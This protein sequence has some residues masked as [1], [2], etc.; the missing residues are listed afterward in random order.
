MPIAAVTDSKWL[1]KNWFF[2]HGQVFYWLESKQSRLVMSWSI[3][4]R[5]SLSIAL[6]IFRSS[7]DLHEC[8]GKQR[9]LQHATRTA[10]TAGCDDV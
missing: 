4:Q 8:T 6:F 10:G 7:V 9:C 5:V 3:D 2:R 1:L